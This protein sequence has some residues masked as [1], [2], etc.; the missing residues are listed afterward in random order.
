MKF[1]NWLQLTIL[2]AL[3]SLGVFASLSDRSKIEEC[4]KELKGFIVDKSERKNRGV[5]IKYKYKVGPQ[6]YSSSEPLNSDLEVRSLN[7]GDSLEILVS[8]EDASVS[9]HKSL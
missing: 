1:K 5:F 9:E 7:I 6:E 2:V 4:S 3:I 8:C